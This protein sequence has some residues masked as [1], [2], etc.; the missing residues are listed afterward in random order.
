MGFD[1]PHP[2]PL[3]KGERERTEFVVRVRAH[4]HGT[5]FLDT[6]V[7]DADR[8]QRGALAGSGAALEASRGVAAM[9]FTR[10]GPVTVAWIVRLD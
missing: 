2:N 5:H 3:P 8:D 9:T 7:H 4:F 6:C 10:P 1:P